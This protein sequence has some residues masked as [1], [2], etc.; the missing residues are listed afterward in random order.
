MVDVDIA[1]AVHRLTGGRQPV[2]PVVAT[3]AV[4]A[5]A[6]RIA[7]ST[8]DSTADSPT[9]RDLLDALAILRWLHAELTS[10]EPTL[11]AAA[12]EAGASWQDLAPALGVASRQAAERRY[13]RLAPT[14][15]PHSTQEAR[16]QAERGRRAGVRA[17]DQ[18]VNANT[19]D[20][21]RLAGQITS[22]TDLPADAAHDIDRLHRALADSNATALPGL[23]AKARRHLRRHPQLADEITTIDTHTR[24]IRHDTT[25]HHGG[26]TSR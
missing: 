16:V 20:L 24:Q 9:D 8:A 7:G 18:W 3:A 15:D 12:R 26:S 14:A 10:L 11:I 5:V 1:Q 17:V 13:L 19:A 23:L 4:T 21:R 22:L 2:D 25:Q 6:T